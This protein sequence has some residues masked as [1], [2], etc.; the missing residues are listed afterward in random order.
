VSWPGYHYGIGKLQT[1]DVTG[2]PSVR[3]EGRPYPEA[4]G[5]S[6]DQREYGQAIAFVPD[7]NSDGVP[8]VL[9][10]GPWTSMDSSIDLLSGSTGSLM[11]RWVPPNTDGLPSATGHSLSLSSDSRQALVG[12]TAFQAYPED[13]SE[14]GQAHLLDVVQMER[15]QTWKLSPRKH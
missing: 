9:V 11:K 15:L 3:W 13:L 10:T 6:G 5:D 2:D 4:D 7:A 8:E 12:G 14:E 1:I